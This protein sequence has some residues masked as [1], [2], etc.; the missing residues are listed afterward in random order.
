M[1]NPARLEQQLN[2][3]WPG[4]ARA[5]L[6]PGRRQNEVVLEQLTAAPDQ[7]GMDAHAVEA[8]DRS[9]DAHGVRVATMPT[10][11]PARRGTAERR[12]MSG[13]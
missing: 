4:R 12:L 10:D 7:S 1:E 9:A 11:Q 13:R 6:A 2:A 5:E 8:V 3:S